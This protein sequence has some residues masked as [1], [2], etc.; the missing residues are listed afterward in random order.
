MVLLF[1]ER[2]RTT[3]NA[4]KFPFPL[5]KFLFQSWFKDHQHM[6]SPVWAGCPV[7]HPSENNDDNDVKGRDPSR[8]GKESHDCTFLLTLV[9]K[10]TETK[11]PKTKQALE[12]GHTF[13]PGFVCSRNCIKDS[14]LLFPLK[15]VSYIPEFTAE[16]KICHLTL[17]LKTKANGQKEDEF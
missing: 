11:T 7:S 15:D 2:K 12:T 3:F 16:F 14:S 9:V 13:L 17:Y 1:H 5:T 4:L 6:G 10:K 8:N